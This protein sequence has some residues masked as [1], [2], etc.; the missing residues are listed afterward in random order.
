MSV[1]SLFPPDQGLSSLVFIK[2]NSTGRASDLI[3]F[4][5]NLDR[6]VGFSRM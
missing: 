2:I 3:R 6:Q 1:S 4:L 5:L